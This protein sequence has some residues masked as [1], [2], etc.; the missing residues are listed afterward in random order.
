ML[1]LAQEVCL[2]VLAYL[3][4][5]LGE[6][7]T[8]KVQAP[9][10]MQVGKVQTTGSYNTMSQSLLPRL[11]LVVHSQSSLKSIERQGMLGLLH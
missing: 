3:A 8:R 6:Q 2:W 1:L 4:A 9:L 7:R 5:L 11:L 10:A